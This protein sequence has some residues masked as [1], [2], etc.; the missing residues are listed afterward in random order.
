MRTPNGHKTWARK[1]ATGDCRSRRRPQG[2]RREAWVRPFRRAHR[3]IASSAHL[4]TCALLAASASSRRA[5]RRP[6]RASW[7][8]DQAS[9]QLVRASSRLEW[10]LRELAEVNECIARE[11][12]TGAEVPGFLLEATEHWAFMTGW[13]CESADEIFAR[14]Q[15]VLDGLLTGALVPERPADRRPRIILAPRPV[16]IRAFLLRRQ[17]RVA[18]RIAPLLRRRRRTPRPRDLRVPQP[19]SFGRAPP[20]FF[21]CLL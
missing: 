10:A 18:D 1:G 20:L 7:E 9:E 6:V 4:I 12:E 13:L 11:P 16:P 2:L 17:P 3:A 5:R 8:L 14:H 15:D 21:D 19:A